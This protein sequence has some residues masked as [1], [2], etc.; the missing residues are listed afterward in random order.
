MT[1]SWSNIWR[2]FIMPQKSILRHF[3]LYYQA[4]NSSPLS[5]SDDDGG[6]EYIW[7]EGK[8]VGRLSGE[9]LLTFNSKNLWS[10]SEMGG[11]GERNQ[12]SLFLSFPPQSCYQQERDVECLPGRLFSLSCR[13]LLWYQ[14]TN[15]LINPTSIPH[16]WMASQL[17]T[18]LFIA[19]AIPHQ[20]L[21]VSTNE[22]KTCK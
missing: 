18:S 13:V 15:T 19:A 22:N 5:N 10:R 11:E 3:S 7:N 14:F 8:L 20:I 4:W 1:A 9:R 17:I 21:I 12:L 6:A 2:K 16:T